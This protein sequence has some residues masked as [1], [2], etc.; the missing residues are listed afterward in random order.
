MAFGG[1]YN[2]GALMSSTLIAPLHVP[3]PLGPQRRTSV[4]AAAEPQQR[5]PQ[6]LQPG[7]FSA[8]IRPGEPSR[9][10]RVHAAAGQLSHDAAIA[11]AAAQDR[12]FPAIASSAQKHKGLRLRAG[13]YAMNCSLLGLA[14]AACWAPEPFHLG[15][16][17]S[18][19]HAAMAFSPVALMVRLGVALDCSITEDAMCPL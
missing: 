9:Q 4:R 15:G 10:T 5:Q 1:R 3:R 8:D 11:A 17:H 18:A 2:A 16:L 6:Q 12:V 7:S 13:V 19:Y 14:A